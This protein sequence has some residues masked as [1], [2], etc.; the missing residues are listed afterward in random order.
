[1][2]GALEI[3]RIVVGAAYVLIAPGLAWSFVFFPASRR[4]DAAEGAEGIDW[5]ER[6]AISFGLSIA[7][8]PIPVFFL[9]T[10]FGVRLS[11]WS[12]AAVVTGITLAAVGILAY[13]R[14]RPRRREPSV[15]PHAPEA[16]QA[17]AAE[18]SGQA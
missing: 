1:M 8:V 5:L 7:L 9:S 4:L 16:E 2:P 10:F 14:Y 3:L 11:A 17:S 15:G 6:G 13:R 18:P 12:A